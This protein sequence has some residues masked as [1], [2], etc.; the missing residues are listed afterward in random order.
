MRQLLFQKQPLMLDL[1]SNGWLARLSLL[2]QH[3]GCQHYLAL[4]H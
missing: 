4:S 1:A 3:Q 2:D